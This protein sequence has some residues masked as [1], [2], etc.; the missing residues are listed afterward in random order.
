MCIIFLTDLVF[1]RKFISSCS[2]KPKFNLPENR[3]VSLILDEMKIKEGLVYN[4]HSGEMIGF[5]HLGDINNELM[6]L[7]QGYEHPIA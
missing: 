6:K 2:R 4:K 3:F 1:R 7:E 5:T